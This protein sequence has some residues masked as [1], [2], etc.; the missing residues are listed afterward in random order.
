MTVG[1]IVACNALGDVIDPDT[2][3]V[4]AGAR[5]AD[6]R[7]LRDTRRALLAGDSAHVN[8][9]IGGMGMNGGIHDAINLTDKLGRVIRGEADDG[10][11]D[12]YARRRVVLRLDDSRQPHRAG[13]R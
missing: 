9:P 8:N 13:P 4:I 3:V 10:L 12:L 6:G 5:T 7:A 11:L 2:A 1:A